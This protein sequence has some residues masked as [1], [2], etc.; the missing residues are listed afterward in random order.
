MVVFPTFDIDLSVHLDHSVIIEQ[1]ERRDVENWN[2]KER[3]QT[4][5]GLKD[6]EKGTRV[7][8]DSSQW[9]RTKGRGNRSKS[10]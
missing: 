8:Q 6:C 3:C 5:S 7:F 10:K 9:C 4:C 1:R 2:T